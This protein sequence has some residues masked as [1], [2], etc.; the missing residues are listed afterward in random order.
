MGCREGG[1]CVHSKWQPS[2]KQDRAWGASGKGRGS[3]ILPGRGCPTQEE[4]GACRGCSIL[5]GQSHLHSSRTP[6]PSGVQALT[7]HTRLSPS[8]LFPSGS[9]EAGTREPTASVAPLTLV[10]PCPQRGEA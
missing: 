8:P 1:S 6:H 3:R 10:H 9:P 2:R 7:L 4:V 5:G